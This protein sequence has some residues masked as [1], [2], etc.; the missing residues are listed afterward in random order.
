MA[1]GEVAL[2]L[3]DGSPRLAEQVFGWNRKTVETGIHEFRSGFRCVDNIA[4]R[5]RK[6]I[7]EKQPQLLPDIQRLV[8]PHSHADTQLQA[9][10]DRLE[11]S[12]SLPWW[13]ITIRPIP[14]QQ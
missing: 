14:V 3:L 8:D 13:D 10:E 2:T 5:R 1:M 12:P 7:E 11:R 6:K 9:L 4:G